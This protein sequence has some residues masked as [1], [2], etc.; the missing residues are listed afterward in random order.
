MQSQF[1]TARRRFLCRNEGSLIGLDGLC[2][3]GISLE[4]SCGTGITSKQ[5]LRI[6]RVSTIEIPSA[7]HRIRIRNSRSS[8]SKLYAILNENQP[9]RITTTREFLFKE[10]CQMPNIA[11]LRSGHAV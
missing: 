8:A 2:I 7:S 4:N 9:T 11:H 5:P 1:P 6:H 3:C 10:L